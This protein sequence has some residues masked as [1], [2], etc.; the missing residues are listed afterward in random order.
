[1]VKES[2]LTSLLLI[3]LGLYGYFSS[4]R[5][6]MT[7]LIPTFFGVGIGLLTLI[8]LKLKLKKH[9]MHMAVLIAFL[10]LLGSLRG[11]IQFIKYILGE[12]IARPFAAKAQVSMFLICLI[13]VLLS[14]RW[15]LKNRKR[16]NNS[17]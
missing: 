5:V 17:A 9:A 4:D 10:G 15:F 14:V 6:S 16:N 3:A 13:Y 11:S 7:A 12:E 8:G 2:F 1:M